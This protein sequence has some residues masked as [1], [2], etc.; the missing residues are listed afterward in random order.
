[1]KETASLSKM[2]EHAMAVARRAGAYQLQHWRKHDFAVEEKGRAADIVTQVD[3]ACEAMIIAE[4]L[5]L[6]EVGVLSEESGHCHAEAP[7]QWVV[8]PLDGTTNY[9]AGLPL[10]N[11]SIGI[12]HQG[13]TVGGV[14][15]APALGELFTAVRGG[16]ALFGQ[17]RA[18]QPSPASDLA[19]AVLATGFPYDKDVNPDNNVAELS[20][21]LPRVRGIRRLGSAALD[22][23]YV[24]AGFLDGYWEMNLHEW[25]VCAAALIATEAGAVVSRYR[26]DR[27]IA[28]MAATPA[29]APTLL[30]LL[31]HGESE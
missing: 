30:A 2:M 7:W 23:C 22:I 29:I 26:P 17:G 13:K 6:G 14:V 10:F 19:H 21:V 1:M 27:G 12:R 25:D 20:R 16:G 3:K 18:I 5:S 9:N 4:A 24:A 11:V 15:Y 28:L 31:R 8:D